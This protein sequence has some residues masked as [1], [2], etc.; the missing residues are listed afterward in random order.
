MVVPPACQVAKI[1]LRM[2][3]CNHGMVTKRSQAFET[4]LQVLTVKHARM[5]AKLIHVQPTGRRWG[6][7]ECMVLCCRLPDSPPQLR[8]PVW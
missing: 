6:P 7:G 4:P 3:R 1:E 5:V 8:V 2:T